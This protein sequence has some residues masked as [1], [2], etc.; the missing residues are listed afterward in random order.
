MGYEFEDLKQSCNAEWRAYIEHDFVGQLGDGSLAAGAFRHYLKQDYLFLIHFA[1][2][3][4]LAAYKSQTLADLKQAKEGMQAIVD[5]EL[6][7]H[8]NYCREWGI[9]EQELATLPE[10]RA[11]LAYTRYVL[12]TGNRG[13]LLDLHVALSPCMV[14]YGEI[15]NWLNARSETVRGAENPYD[16]WI[17]MYESEE[18]QNAMAAEIHWLNNRLSDVTPARFTEL[19]RIFSEATRLEIDFWDMG[20]EQRM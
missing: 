14:G 1:R 3:F 19:S 13:D 4:A 5:V 18:F 6:G 11:T 8:V 12:D 2:A 7:L 9:S 20:L 16:A 15:A 17:A 10:A